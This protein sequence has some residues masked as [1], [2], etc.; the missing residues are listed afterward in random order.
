MGRG[1]KEKWDPKKIF[2]RFAPEIGPHF[3]FASYTPVTLRRF[4]AIEGE[5]C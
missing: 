3:Q 2:R 1:P 4:D 5:R